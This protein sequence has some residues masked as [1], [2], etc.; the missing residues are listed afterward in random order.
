MANS[1]VVIEVVSTAKG[2]KMTTKQ[3]D[4]QA[5]SVDKLSGSQ[6]K[7]GKRTDSTNKKEKALYQTNLSSAKGFSKMNQTIGGSSG[8]GALVGSYA[9][10]AAN[11]FAVTAAFNTLRRAAAVE[12]LAEGLTQFSASTGQSLDLV[13]QRLQEATGYAVSFEESMKTAALLTSAGFGTEEMEGL[14]K[15]A[16]G[17]SLALGR[18]MGDALDRLTRG[19]VKLEPEILD[20]LGIMVRLDEATQNYAAS[21]GK[22]A[23]ALTTFERQQA[24]MNA[25]ITEGADKFSQIGENIDPNAY[26]KLSAAFADLTKNVLGFLNGALEPT[27]NFLL[28]NSGIFIGLVTLFASSILNKMLPA[29]G[30]MATGSRVAAAAAL[31]SVEIAAASGANISASYTKQLKVLKGFPPSYLNIVGSIKQGTA[32]T[33]EMTI[34]QGQLTRQMNKMVKEA[35]GDINKL[36]KTQRKYYD[37]LEQTRDAVIGLKGAQEGTAAQKALAVAQANLAQSEREIEIYAEMERQTFTLAGSFQKWKNVIRLTMSSLQAYKVE[38]LTAQGLQKGAKTATD[39]WSIALINLKVVVR[40]LTISFKGLGVAIKSALPFLGIIIIVGQIAIGIVKWLAKLVFGWGSDEAIAAKEAWEEFG[41]VLDGIPDKME[42]VNQ[43]M[44]NASHTGTPLIKVLKTLGGLYRTVSEEAIKAEKAQLKSGDLADDDLYWWS[45]A[46]GLIGDS[47]IAAGLVELEKLDS[48]FADFVGNRIKKETDNAASSVTGYIDHMIDAGMTVEEIRVKLLNLQQGASIAFDGIAASAESTDMAF[49]ELDKT[50][51]NFFRKFG[52]KTIYDELATSMG[53]VTA[54]IQQTLNEIAQGGTGVD[55]DGLLG[56]LSKSLTATT[57]TLYGEEVNSLYQERMM[58]GAEIQKLEKEQLSLFGEELAANKKLVLIEKG[59]YQTLSKEIGSALIQNSD[60]ANAQVLALQNMNAQLKITMD[61]YKELEKSV[62]RIGKDQF[63]TS[64]S[65]LISNASLKEQKSELETTLGIM[66]ERLELARQDP[67]TG[68]NWKL[69]IAESEMLREVEKLEIQI[70][71]ETEQQARIRLAALDS[72]KQQ[73]DIE[74]SL[75]NLRQGIRGASAGIAARRAGT[76]MTDADSA[77]QA[78]DFAKEKFNLALKEA[79]L[80]L[81]VLA[82]EFALVAAQAAQTKADNQARIDELN[83]KKRLSQET[84]D[85]IAKIDALAQSTVTALNTPNLSAD[86]TKALGLQLGELLSERYDLETS[87]MVL[88]Q[89]DQDRVDQLEKVNDLI[90]QSLESSKTV[91]QSQGNLLRTELIKSALELE[92]S[93]TDM[94]SNLSGVFTQQGGGDLLVGMAEAIG[95]PSSEQLLKEKMQGSLEQIFKDVGQTADFST[96]FSGGDESAISERLAAFEIPDSWT[97]EQKTRF[98]AFRDNY[99]EMVEATKGKNFELA[100]SF[101][102]LAASITGI[103]GEE[104]AVLASLAN[105][106]AFTLNTIDSWN[107]M[108]EGADL[109]AEGFQTAANVI[110]QISGIMAA[111]SGQQIKEVDKQI[112]AEKKRDGKSKESLAKIK[113]LEKKKEAMERKRFN[114]QKKLMMAQTIA[115][116][117]AGMMKTVGETGFFGI[118]LAAIVAAMGAAQ[119]AIISKQKY[120]GSTGSVQEPKKQA[121]NIGKAANKIDISRGAQAGEIGYL[122]GQRGMPG[123]AAGMKRYA[124]GGPIVVGER[125]PEIVQPT[126]DGYNVIPNDQLGG[127]GGT[128]VNFTINAVDA[129]GVEQL[130]VDQRG[131]IIEM[132]KEAANSTGERFLEDVDTQAMGATGGGYGG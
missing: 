11:V 125:G 121:L 131:N 77:K 123:G 90:D 108:E 2:L 93:T 53:A 68:D 39:L 26:D 76:T 37:A 7:L 30:D 18:D 16:K 91:L 120:E 129:T 1:K 52:K 117:A 97:E 66:K 122:R 45:G 130:L 10:L 19:A 127:M 65:I 106:S 29:L 102:Q 95:G 81:T 49:K 61:Y 111:H 44:E 96:I 119:L 89:A 85:E 48:R 28:N 107:A 79:N 94:L 34:A 99:I 9:I 38:L 46:E 15:V 86:Q 35:G 5:K 116:T 73:L 14:T 118:P 103:F 113:E 80:K 31:E 114:Q 112:A 25:I 17:A 50:T 24:F 87:G 27:I 88:A 3:V 69:L 58:L 70:T 6:E 59:R 110:G 128:N 33:K 42:A 101:S 126:S 41:T 40:G 4:D 21:I 100:N 75:L 51:G 132:I 47:P 115:N 54:S 82:A 105:F 64:A 36:T 72:L 67:S 92:N 124:D 71:A 20:E 98:A 62:K 74:K 83:T 57:A 43:T 55:R 84:K 104:G 56:E 63:I 78:L 23:G 12:K 32:T 8:S 60:S 109:T 13:S 22:S